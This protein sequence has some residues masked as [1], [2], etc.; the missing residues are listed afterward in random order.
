MAAKELELKLKVAEAIQDDVN[1]GIVRVDS[2]LMNRVKVRPGDIVEIEGDRKTVAIIDRA[3]PGDIGLN[4]IRM[5]GIIRRNAKAGIGDMIKIRKADVKEAK[6]VVIAPSSK[7]VM[8]RASPQIFKQGLLGRALSKGDIVSLGGTKR[9][10]TTMAESPFFEDMFSML[11]ESLMGFGLG[12]IKFIVADT[13]PKGAVVISELTEVV[14]NPDAAVVEEEKV[15]DVT[16]EDVGGLDEEIRK[17]R[18]MVELPLKHPELFQRLGIEPPKGV[19][20]HGAPGTGKTLLAKAVANET[21]SSFFLINGPEVMCV[22]PETPI[23]TNPNGFK[24]AKNLFDSAEGK[25]LRNDRMKVIELKNPVSSYG[26]DENN[27]VTKVKITHA[28]KLRAQGF[29][30]SLSDG[31]DILTSQN[32]PF[33]VYENGSLVWKKTSELKKGM[34]V[35]KISK[36][37]LPSESYLIDI[38]EIKNKAADSKGYYSVK[39]INLKRSNFIKLPEKTSKELLEFLGLMFAE[40]NISKKQDAVTFCNNNVKLRNHYKQLLNKLF[41]IN[42]TKEYADGRVVCYSKILIKYLELLGLFPGKKVLQIPDY[43]FRL[44]KQEI[45]A[46]IRGYF[47]G[48]GTVALQAVKTK[49]RNQPIN[50]PT[51]VLYSSSKEFLQQIQ[52]LVNLKLDIQMKLKEH[53]TPKGIMHKLVVAGNKGRKEFMYGIGAI[54]KEKRDRLNLI[55]KFNQKKEF[56]HIPFPTLLVSRLRKEVPYDAYRNNDWYVY[57][58][59]DFTKHAL[60]KLYSIADNC[61]IVDNALRKEYEILTRQDICWERIEKIDNAGETELIDFTVDKNNFIGSNML[62]LHNSKYYGQSEENLRKIFEDA[63]KNAPSIIF[64]DEVDA[65]APKREEMRGD[66]ERRVVAQLLALMDG[67][68]SRGKVVVIAATNIPN[69]LDPAL[70]RP[71]RFDRE[72][73]IAVPNVIGRENVLKIHTRNMPLSKDV[74]LKELALITHGFVGADLSAL[75]KEA[76]MVLLRKILPDLK[77]KEEESI[78]KE[79]LEKLIIAQKDFL[80]ALKFV[81]PSAMREVLVEKPNVRWT[82]VG[83]LEDVKQELTEA[84]E[85]PLKNPEAFKRL[86]I[87]P[88]K[89]ILLYGAPGTGKTMLAKAVATETESNF[90]LVKGPELLCLGGGTLVFTDHCGVNAV[91]T[92]YENIMPVSEIVEQTDR[93]EVRKIISPVY[94]YAVDENGKIIKTKIVSATKLFVKDAYKIINEDNNEIEVS[95]N[96]PLLT[97][98]NNEIRWIKAADLETGDFVAKPSHIPVFDRKISIGLPKY[99]HLR[100]IREDESNYYVRIFSTKEITRLPKYLTPDLAEFLG[101]FVAEGNISKEGISI[102][103]KNA[104]YRGRIKKLM[105]QFVDKSRIASY[106]DKI[107]FYSTPFVK[108]LESI[109]GMKLGVKKSHIIKMP[110]IVSKSS[111]EVIKAFLRGAYDGDGYVGKI[112]VE[113]GTMSENLASGIVYLLALLG[114]KCKYWKRKDSMHLVTL[115]GQK[116]IEKFMNSVYGE[117]KKTALRRYYNAKYTIPDVS[118]LLRKTKDRL[119]LTYGKKIP[120]GL[121]DGVINKRKKCGLIRFQRI[122]EYVNRNLTTEFKKSEEYKTLTK[123]A[124][125]DFFWTKILK[126]DKA[127]PQWMYDLETE[128]DSFIGGK[129]PTFLHNS[130]WVG[131]SEK[132]VRDIFKKARQVSP[133]VVCFD[134]IDALASKRGGHADSRVTESVVNQM[135]TEMDGL[136]ELTNVV[137]IATTNRPDIIDSALLR[138]GRFDRLVLTPIPDEKMRVKIFE[139]HTKNMPIAA[140]VRVAELAKKTEGYAGGD[141]EAVCREAAIF[142]LREDMESTKVL[143]KHFDKALEKVRPSVTKE[144]EQAYNKIQDTLRVKASSEIKEKPNYFG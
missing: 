29:K 92:F 35:A 101:W 45:A 135:L 23:F 142:A 87:K 19:L 44:P 96:Q 85:W 4:I 79:L 74:D 49:E 139:V 95:A 115:S 141:I 7:G 70:R 11:D 63:E 106:D 82:D 90:I 47:E 130:K 83:G 54:T 12:D 109:F 5:D 114:I 18:E 123:I 97:F 144:I 60:N 25:V 66:V 116:E 138:P 136:E 94:T 100:L 62:L 37:K 53:K 36:L 76:A 14:F 21:N 65:I 10:R 128:H 78:P 108:Y 122:M 33:L 50:Y 61:R 8:I 1:K 55:K 59:G 84:V 40:G 91:E 73:E 56:R 52:S 93:L 89:G 46:F 104:G 117:T 118:D 22:G 127:E 67:L 71:G 20:L 51:P 34:F 17:I 103:N 99:E 107:I 15:L 57:G 77:L 64:I 68:K 6:K 26:L 72:I 42:K 31:N 32:Q 143:K 121:V 86:G 113:Y 134:E 88:P 112:K 69:V 105:E 2:S 132:A 30:V 140:D 81:R 137:V 13:N 3:Y 48:D 28:V 58:H 129:V 41:G 43:F 9:R 120:E 126:I 39:S 110:S 75:S 27:E 102:C 133:T 124:E 131:E 38:N 119:C 125:G 16:Y 111:S 80:E 24:T 98:R